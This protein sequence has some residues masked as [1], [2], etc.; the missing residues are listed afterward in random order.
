MNKSF[1]LFK[2]FSNKGSV[3]EL[4]CAEE[5]MTEKIVE[6]CDDVSIIGG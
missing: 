4:S 6:L 3:S 2:R 1:E 5:L